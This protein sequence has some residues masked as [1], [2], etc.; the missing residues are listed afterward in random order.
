MY[1]YPNSPALL[2]ARSCQCPDIPA[3]KLTYWYIPIAETKMLWYILSEFSAVGSI[4][5][6][7]TQALQ[8]TVPVP[9]LGNNGKEPFHET[10]AP[11]NEINRLRQ[12]PGRHASHRDHAVRLQRFCRARHFDRRHG[13]CPPYELHGFARG[14]DGL[15][16]PKRLADPVLR[17]PV[18]SQRVDRG[19][20][21]G[22]KQCVDHSAAETLEVVVGRD[23]RASARR[24][25]S[26][27][28][29]AD[30]VRDGLRGC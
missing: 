26:S 30:D 20:S 13:E 29:G 25:D 17:S 27:S 7:R 10:R 16:M 24:L 12:A 19:P 14:R 28:F 2:K 3:L 8:L 22:E 15:E 18:L 1:Q 23:R 5:H 9:M 21:A 6:Y 11:L 4:S